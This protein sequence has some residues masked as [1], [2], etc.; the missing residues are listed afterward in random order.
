MSDCCKCGI[1]PASLAF[2]V[3]HLKGNDVL[4]VVFIIS[5][6]GRWTVFC[7]CPSSGKSNSTLAKCD[8]APELITNYF[9]CPFN[10]WPVHLFVL[11]SDCGCLDV[12]VF[13]SSCSSSMS[14]IL[15]R[16]GAQ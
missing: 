14:L 12:T 13:I 7:H 2:D 5:P 11:A 9:T 3:N 16:S 1:T 6:S 15:S 10:I 4:F 8:V